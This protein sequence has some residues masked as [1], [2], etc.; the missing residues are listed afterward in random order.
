[1]SDIIN[2]NN[3]ISNK[4]LSII[5]VED[6]NEKVEE[7]T[8]TILELIKYWD[9]NK[10]NF[11][12]I[13]AKIMEIVENYNN[14]SGNDKKIICILSATKILKKISND[15]NE[16]YILLSLL[17]NTIEIIINLTKNKKQRKNNI[18]IDNDDIEEI[19]LKKLIKED[20][21]DIKEILII[22]LTLINIIDEYQYIDIIKRKEILVKTIRKYYNKMDK[23]EMNENNK[24]ILNY[25][26]INLEKII[27]YM[28]LSKQ[29][30]YIINKIKKISLKKILN[31]ISCI[32]C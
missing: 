27:D 11:V 2:N 14:L 28:V 31:K 1:M 13:I 4:E 30:K 3:N 9:E 15:K 23:S 19:L 7:I 32:K 22:I 17:P 8:N 6:V 26:M 29:G 16:E 12:L 25:V 10:I 24:L 18:K 5:D 20:T 21:N